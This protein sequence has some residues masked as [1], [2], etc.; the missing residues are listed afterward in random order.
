MKLIEY[1]ESKRISQTDF[2]EQIGC[3][4]SNLNKIL[5]G[6]HKPSWAIML[7]I[8]QATKCKVKPNDFFEKE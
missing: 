2:A 3:S 1:I 7:K 6:E 8:T 5:H 4:T